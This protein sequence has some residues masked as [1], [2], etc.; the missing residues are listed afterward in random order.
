MVWRLSDVSQ[1]VNEV[2]R[3]ILAILIG[4]KYSAESRRAPVTDEEKP[5][6]TTEIARCFIRRQRGEEGFRHQLS[7]GMREFDKLE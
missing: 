5:V 7:G 4:A 3:L 2:P 1:K 6:H